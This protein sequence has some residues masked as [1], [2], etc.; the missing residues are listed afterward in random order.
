[1]ALEEELIDDAELGVDCSVAAWLRQR[2]LRA[3]AGVAAGRSDARV[4]RRGGGCK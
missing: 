4:R 3:E 2:T 1:M